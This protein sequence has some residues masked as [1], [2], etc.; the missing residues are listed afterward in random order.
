MSRIDNGL[1][2]L[3]PGQG[4]QSIGM[5]SELSEHHPQVAETFREASRALDYD[6]WEIVSQGPAE[7]LNS[8]LYTQP[9]MLAAGVAAWRVW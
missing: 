6:L 9:A 5:L 2:F 1:A 3:F 4:S 7:Q 8:T